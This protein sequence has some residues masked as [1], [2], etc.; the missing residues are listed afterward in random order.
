MARMRGFTLIEA[1][2][3]LLIMS[4][5]ASLAWPS[6]AGYVTKT[7]RMEGKVALILALQRQEQH[8]ALHH[9][10]VAFSSMEP[11]A[12]LP[13]WSG[14]D[15]AGSAYELDAEACPG[16]ELR[17]CVQV[18]ARPGTAKVDARFRDDECGTLSLRSTGEQ[19]ASG[20]SARCWP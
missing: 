8:H 17:D 5:L 2:V 7:R 20:Q 14:N 1:M 19:G 13:W 9:T 3:V 6:Y 12:Q 18:R 11:V 4:V 16:S 10:Y 15:A